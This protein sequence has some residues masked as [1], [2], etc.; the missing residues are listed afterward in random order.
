MASRIRHRLP[1]LLLLLDA[2][3]SEQA[4]FKAFFRFC[5]QPKKGQFF[6]PRYEKE[7]QLIRCCWAC[8]LTSKNAT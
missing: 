3:T 2:W 4:P 1:L 6:P 7:T 5:N 8:V